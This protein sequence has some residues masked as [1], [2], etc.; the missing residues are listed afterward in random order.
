MTGALPAVTTEDNFHQTSAG[1]DV[2]SQPKDGNATTFGTAHYPNYVLFIILLCLTFLFYFEQGTM[3]QD[4]GFTHQGTPL[5]CLRSRVGIPRR[6][7][8][9][10]ELW[11]ASAPLCQ[12]TILP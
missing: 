12:R 5:W 8:S 1:L 9:R 3:S 10:E 7:H 2:G 6:L 4:H 11:Q